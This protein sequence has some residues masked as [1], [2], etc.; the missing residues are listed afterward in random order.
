MASAWRTE[1]LEYHELGIQD[2]SGARQALRRKRREAD[3]KTLRT[4]ANNRIYPPARTAAIDFRTI[5]SGI[6]AKPLG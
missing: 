2:G 1:L 5:N 3:S 6:T 4:G